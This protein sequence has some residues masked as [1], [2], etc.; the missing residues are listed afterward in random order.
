ML[1]SRTLGLA[2]SMV[3][4]FSTT[5]EVLGHA[6][7]DQSDPAPGTELVAAPGAVT[8]WFTEELQAQDSWIRVFASDGTR[9]DLDDSRIL[10]DDE[11]GLTVSLRPGLGRGTYSVS[12]QNLA[13]DGDGLTGS[14]RFG[15]GEVPA[16]T[17]AP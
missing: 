14:F 15:I 13:K 9:A 5:S 11:K 7:F 16:T 8:S 6:H 12:W 2:L 1:T 3:L 17:D 4:L 10:S